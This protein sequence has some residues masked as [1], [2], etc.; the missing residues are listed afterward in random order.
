M[1]LQVGEMKAKLRTATVKAE[2]EGPISACI[3][4]LLRFVRD[5]TTREKILDE[6]MA[7]HVEMTKDAAARALAAQSTTTPEPL[8]LELD[9]PL[10]EPEQ[11]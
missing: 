1:A 10:P 3:V 8:C 2:V 5:A 4:D 6:M 9:G 11:P 7:L